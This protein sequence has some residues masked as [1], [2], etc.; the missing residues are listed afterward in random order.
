MY[1]EEQTHMIVLL[2]LMSSVTFLVYDSLLTL[3]AEI[4]FIWSRYK[5]CWLKWYFVVIRYCSLIYL[6]LVLGLEISCE[7]GDVPSNFS[8]KHWSVLKTVVGNILIIVVQALLIIRGKYAN[9]YALY[10]R[11]KLLARIFAVLLTMEC[12]TTVLNVAFSV[13]LRNGHDSDRDVAP[14]PT[15]FVIFGVVPVSIQLSVVVLTLLRSRRAMR[16]GWGHRT[17][18]ITLMIRDGSIAFFLL[19]GEHFIPVYSAQV[20]IANA[21]L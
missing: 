3:G 13:H 15:L 18:I 14:P 6:S 9:L 2:M 19:F 20:L 12:F 7:S 5:H 1:D 11:S 17:P 4:E 8:V 16:R 21:M 10:N